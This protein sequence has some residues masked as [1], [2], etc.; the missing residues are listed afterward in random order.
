MS[1]GVGIHALA[2]AFLLLMLSPHAFSRSY[3][4]ELSDTGWNTGERQSTSL[5]MD[6]SGFSMGH[7]NYSRYG[8]VGINDVRVKDRTS[9]QNGT[10]YYIDGIHLSSD[11]IEDTTFEFQKNPDSQ[12]YLLTVNETWPV[13]IDASRS[14]DFSGKSINDRAYFG[15]NYENAGSSFLH[16]T[17][18]RKDTS[19]ILDLRNVHFYAVQ[20][21]TTKKMVVDEFK[22]NLTMLYHDRS[23]F[24]GLGAFKT[25]HSVNRKPSMVDEESYLGTFTVTR[26]INSTSANVTR[27]WIY[28]NGRGYDWLGGCCMSPGELVAYSL[29]ESLEV[30]KNV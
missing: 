4:I 23:S 19:V 20:N 16:A 7:G 22:P 18:L 21:D 25:T 26:N 28:Y 27:P 10:L 14:L 3:Y 30:I 11:D 24:T 2:V 17:N 13:H 15:N 29:P 6:I 5:T 1:L 8:E 12:D 9:S